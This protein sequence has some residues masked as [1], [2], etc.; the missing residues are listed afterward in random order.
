[1]H[2]YDRDRERLRE[3]DAHRDRGRG[4][5]YAVQKGG[6]GLV[7]EGIW[8]TG[9]YVNKDKVVEKLDLGLRL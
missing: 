7:G 2:V 1:M 4:Y 8:G 9:N 3:R 6:R 5:I